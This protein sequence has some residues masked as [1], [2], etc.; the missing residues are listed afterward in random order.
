MD[1]QT[2]RRARTL[3]IESKKMKLSS[4]ELPFL[5]ISPPPVVEMGMGVE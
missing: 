1:G 2:D 3:D 5:Y 4:V